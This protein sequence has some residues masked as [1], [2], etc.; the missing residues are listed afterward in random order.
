MV[1]LDT[2]ERF[3]TGRERAPEVEECSCP[4]GYKGYSCEDCDVGYTRVAEG[5]YLGSCDPCN[6]N[7][8]SKFCDAERGVCKV[9]V[10]ELQLTVNYS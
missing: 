10:N 6:C 1:S 3:N 4:A 9:N 7:G 8:H 5:I 2:A